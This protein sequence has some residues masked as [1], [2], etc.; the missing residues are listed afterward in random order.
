MIRGV[1]CSHRLYQRNCSVQFVLEEAVS[2]A[3]V[4]AVP[5]CLW[6]GIVV[7]MGVAGLCLS[8]RAWVAASVA[9]AVTVAIAIT[10][11][12]NNSKIGGA[13][14]AVVVGISTVG[15]RD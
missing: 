11:V 3:V 13:C 8:A 7:S 10:R 4:L 6:I 1:M 9:V 15:A 2:V 14:A 12:C 5:V